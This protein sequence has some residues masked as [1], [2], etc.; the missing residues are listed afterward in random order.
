MPRV[1]QTPIRPVDQVT[2][3]AQEYAGPV[4]FAILVIS[5]IHAPDT[6]YGDDARVAH[7]AWL[8]KQAAIAIG[9][10]VPLPMSP[11][12]RGHQAHLPIHMRGIHE[13]GPAA[14]ASMSK[15]AGG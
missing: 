11:V 6:V 2:G 7:F 10:S 15:K 3:G 8:D 9:V 4:R 1:H 12:I 5:V 14:W 13:Q